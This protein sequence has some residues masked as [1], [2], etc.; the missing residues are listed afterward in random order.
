LTGEVF[1]QIPRFDQPELEW[2]RLTL[3][4]MTRAQLL[5]L[6]AEAPFESRQPQMAIATMKGAVPL[7]PADG[8]HCLALDAWQELT[9]QTAEA[10]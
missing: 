9:Q 4:R 6:I 3:E 5:D 10:R 8:S 7:D 2:C 1:E